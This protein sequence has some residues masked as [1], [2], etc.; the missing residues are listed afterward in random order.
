MADF[1]IAYQR[2]LKFE[3]G[4]V[5]D[6]KDSGGETYKG[7]SR[8][9]NPKWSG[10]AIVDSYKNKPN[11]PKNLNSDTKLQ[12]LVKECYR[13]NYWKPVWGDRIKNQRV[14]DDVYDSGVNLGPA[15]S[16]KLLQRQW[17]M[18]ETGKMD[19]TLLAKLN[20]VKEL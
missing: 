1:N 3:G 8:K 18:K 17:K 12:E 16:I 6:P 2:T 9:N 11:F 4:Y 19:E 7:I 14:A 13:D 10:W 20:S 5:N 15:M